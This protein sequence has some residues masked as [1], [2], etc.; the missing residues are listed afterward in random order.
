M[1]NRLIKLLRDNVHASARQPLRAESSEN[2]ATIYLYDVIVSDDYWGGV[3]AESFVR[4][5]VA[6]DAPVI[7]LRINSPG[8]D[9]FAARA[10]EAA[11]REHKSKI[12]AHVDGYAA[13]AA[14]YVAI[15]AD[16]VEMSPGAFFM[17][18]KAWTVGLGNADDMRKEADL[19]D[20]IDGSLAETYASVTGKTVDE[21]ME[22]MAA[23]T[24]LTAAESVDLGFADRVSEDAPKDCASWN[25]A[26]YARA[27]TPIETQRQEASTQEHEQVP[28]PEPTRDK[29]E[30]ISRLYDNFTR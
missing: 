7:H 26:A 6:V 20:K 4:E 16:E 28:D 21:I 2:E 5:L 30:A 24:W 14:S 22:M 17:I 8:G 15:A 3:G 1:N 23:E 18:H 13:S 19:L 27:P 10:I 29:Y 11:I 25:L 12:V 9:V